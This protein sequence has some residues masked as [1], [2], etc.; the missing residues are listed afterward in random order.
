[1]PPGNAQFPFPQIVAVHEG[2][3]TE[4]SVELGTSRCSR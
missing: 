4:V 1:M 3:P 2:E